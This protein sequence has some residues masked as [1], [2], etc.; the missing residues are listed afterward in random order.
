MLILLE[1]IQY[2][3]QTCG[4]QLEAQGNASSTSVDENVLPDFVSARI[5]DLCVRRL[6]SSRMLHIWNIFTY[7]WLKFMVDVSKYSIHGAKS[8]WFFNICPA[9][10]LPSV[11]L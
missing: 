5:E 11:F 9:T 3:T 8:S 10:Y 4:H 6:R 7:I 1:G 2:L